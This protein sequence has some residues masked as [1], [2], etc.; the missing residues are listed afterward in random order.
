M[1]VFMRHRMLIF[2]VSSSALLQLAAVLISGHCLARYI[3]PR[4]HKIIIPDTG[5]Y[6]TGYGKDYQNVQASLKAGVCETNR[7]GF[8]PVLPDQAGAH[9]FQGVTVRFH[10]ILY[11]PLSVDAIMRKLLC[12]SPFRI[13]VFIS[14][15]LTRCR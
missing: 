5:Y 12:L 9:C 4:T 13:L 14:M 10:F 2:N 15:K 8:P 3:L 7:G 1:L 6:K 11:A